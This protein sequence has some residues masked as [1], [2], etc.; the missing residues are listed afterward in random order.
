MKTTIDGRLIPDACR[1]CRVNSARTDGRCAVCHDYF[2]Q[3]GAERYGKA[4]PLDSVPEAEQIESA[5]KVARTFCAGTEPM[6]TTGRLRPA[7]ERE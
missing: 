1:V 4:L 6:E 3:R 2:Q 7:T 5:K